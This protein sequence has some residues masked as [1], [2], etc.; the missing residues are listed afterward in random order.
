M[1]LTLDSTVHPTSAA[2][3]HELFDSIVREA[4]EEIGL[5]AT[6]LDPPKFLGIVANLNTGGRCGM[7]FYCESRL[8]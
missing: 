6:E 8:S 4:V 3:T 1:G 2:V 7:V 5:S